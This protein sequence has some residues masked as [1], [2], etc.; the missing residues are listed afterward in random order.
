MK[1]TLAMLLMGALA[2]S[3][4]AESYD[5]VDA[6]I[7]T[8]NTKLDALNY[9]NGDSFA[10]TFSIESLGYTGAS[11]NILTLGS[12]TVNLR[13]Q[14]ADNGSASAYLGLRVNGSESWYANPSPTT[15]TTWSGDHFT[16]SWDADTKTNSL[17]FDGMTG[18]WLTMGENGKNMAN[19]L[20]NT[21]I[22]IAY[23][24][25][26]NST[27]LTLTVASGV[28]DTVTFQNTA[29]NARE[30]ARAYNSTKTKDL[31]VVPEPATATLSLLALAALAARRKRK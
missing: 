25:A 31:V 7:S 19:G 29:L 2:G 10:I 30:I 18:L 22:T 1:K 9:Q 20:L 8:I 15:S 17:T 24:K 14:A 3:A 11:A 12:S 6:L 27:S 26:T 5:N 16:A 28:T 23:D 21:P 13:I 4:F